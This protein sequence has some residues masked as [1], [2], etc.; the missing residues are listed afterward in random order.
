MATDQ[1]SDFICQT[2]S[3]MRRGARH[4]YTIA[5]YQV[6]PSGTEKVKRAI[7][8]FV[9][10]VKSI[11]RSEPVRSRAC[12]GAQAIPSEYRPRVSGG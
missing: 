11:G 2:T 3:G 7:E 4:G 8:E 12:A 10:Y 9:Q 6:K 1:R 5:Q